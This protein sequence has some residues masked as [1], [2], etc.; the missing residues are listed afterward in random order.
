MIRAESGLKTGQSVP[1]AMHEVADS[2]LEK[3]KRVTTPSPEPEDTAVH[4]ASHFVPIIHEA[5]H[6]V[7]AAKEGAVV[8]IQRIHRGNTE[9]RLTKKLTLATV[10]SKKAS[11]CL[12]L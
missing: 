9:R 3:I 5:D 10:L 12:H 2:M 7:Q 4:R 8:R 11:M 1:S 6:K